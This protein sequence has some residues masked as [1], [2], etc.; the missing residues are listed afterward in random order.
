MSFDKLNKLIGVDVTVFGSPILLDSIIDRNGATC[1][2]E[3]HINDYCF[4]DCH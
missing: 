1:A 4:E 2:A 3:M